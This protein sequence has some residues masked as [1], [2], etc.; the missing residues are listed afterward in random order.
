MFLLASVAILAAILNISNCS[1][2]SAS[3]PLDAHYRG[4]KDVQS[5][6]KKLYLSGDLTTKY[7]LLNP[8]CCRGWFS[9]FFSSHIVSTFVNT[10]HMFDSRRID[11]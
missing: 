6:E 8:V 3:Y 2:I 7:L 5:S 9:S 10:L 1:T 4:P 11:L